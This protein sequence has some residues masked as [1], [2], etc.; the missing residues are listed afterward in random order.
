MTEGIKHDQGK[1]DLSLISS[2]LMTHLARVRE[3]GAT[4]YERDNWK[5]GFKY[6][7]S[8]AAALRHIMAFKDGEDLDPESGL[9]HVAHAI[10]CLE[11]LLYDFVHR[12][13]TN[14][15]RYRKP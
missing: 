11:H 6:N 14:D 10:A 15:D 12:P 13:T 2:E 1:P 3:F 8:I 4:K 7:R 5:R 9:C